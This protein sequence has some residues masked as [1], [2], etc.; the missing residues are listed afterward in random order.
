MP[1]HRHLKENQIVCSVHSQNVLN[2]AKVNNSIVC[3][4]R[5]GLFQRQIRQNIQRPFFD[6]IIISVWQ[7]MF[8]K[9]TKGVLRDIMVYM[10]NSTPC[11]NPYIT[12]VV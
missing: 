1:T 6:T 2:Y 10:N 12:N 8:G 3:R 11:F 4:F 5:L 7:E 9:S